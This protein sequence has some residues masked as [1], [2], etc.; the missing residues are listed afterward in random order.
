MGIVIQST[1]DISTDYGVN[2]LVYGQSGIG[3]TTLA[4]TMPDPI[5]L[6]AE[7]GLLSL[8]HLDLPY[9]EIE[10]F[11]MFQEVFE[12]I[13]RSKE[14]DV[15]QSIVV[16]SISEIAELLL[17]D[18]LAT[19]KDGRAAYGEMAFKMVKALKALR[20]L[21]TKHV[22][23]TAKLSKEQD[24]TDR[25][26]YSAGMPGRV[27]P[28][29]IPHL[30]DEVFAMVPVKDPKSKKTHRLL[31]TDGDSKWLAKDRSGMLDQYE[32]PDLGAIIAK[33]QSK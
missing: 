23:M 19:N 15:F 7:A 21:K 28:I 10:T 4:A 31:L 1:E 17:Q 20:D 32:Q 2:I 9:I 24:E 6:S 33:I 27:I 5:I 26:V 25:L 12:W 3:K 13:Q 29:Q 14:A 22:Y 18:E 16:D 8:S 11:D 30:I